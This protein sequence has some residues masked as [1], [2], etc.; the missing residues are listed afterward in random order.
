MSK[1]LP[2]GTLKL[3]E[4]ARV[5][6]GTYGES[7]FFSSYR[8]LSGM[9]RKFKESRRAGKLSGRVFLGV[10]WPTHTPGGPGFQ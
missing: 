4:G 10:L 3:W 2:L 1:I 6:R 7:D 5:E 8:C 9:T